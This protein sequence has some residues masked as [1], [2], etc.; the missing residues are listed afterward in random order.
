[1]K[2]LVNCYA[3]SPY[4]GSEPGMGWNFVKCLSVHHELHIITECKY[5]D[6]LDKYF[7]EHPEERTRYNFYFVKRERHNV[8]RKIWPPSYYWFYEKWQRKVHELAKEL[9]DIEDFD[10]IHQLNMVGYREPGYLWMMNKPFVWGP[11]GGFNI[12][13]WRL[14]HTMGPKGFVFYFARNVINLYQMRFSA[15]VSKAAKRSNAIIC[16]TRDDAV[17]VRKL[18]KKKALLFQR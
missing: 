14:L 13:P 11:M 7:G 5:R 3:C 10:I 6:D 9:D 17:A 2:I 1:M 8:L 15:R 16:A 4:Q 18:W 12:T